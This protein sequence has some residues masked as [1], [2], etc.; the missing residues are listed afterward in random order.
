M[1]NGSQKDYSKEAYEFELLMNP[2]E[3][4]NSINLYGVKEVADKF[5]IGY[6][7]LY[8]AA[9]KYD[10][11]LPRTNLYEI[12]IE[13]WLNENNIVFNHPDRI[14][15][16]PKE[17]DFYFPNHNFAIEFQGTYWHMDPRIYEASDHNKSNHKTAQE[18]WDKDKA[19]ADKCCEVGIDLLSIW[20]SDWNQNK[21]EIKEQILTILK[22]KT[23]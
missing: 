7:A 11:I 5:N 14:Q 19:K 6:T 4:Q 9:R 17:L 12:E 8:G 2:I 22:G 20:E 10:L 21:E 18:I 15:I 3:L 1:E 23:K 16:K 13:K